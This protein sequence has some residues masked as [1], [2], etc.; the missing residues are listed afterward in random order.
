MSKSSQSIDGMA[1][2]IAVRTL[3]LRLEPVP[4]KQLTFMYPV[5]RDSVEELTTPYRDCR[6][7]SIFC[8]GESVVVGFSGVCPRDD[9]RVFGVGIVVAGI[10]CVLYMLGV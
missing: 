3:L 6:W 5:Q 8:D 7:I 4:A 10:G 1:V 2:F 9:P